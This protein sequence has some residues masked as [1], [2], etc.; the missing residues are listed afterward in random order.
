[1]G[2]NMKHFVYHGLGDLT[3]SYYFQLHPFT[4]G[5]HMFIFK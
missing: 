3:Q 5:F 2:E 1:M 4:C